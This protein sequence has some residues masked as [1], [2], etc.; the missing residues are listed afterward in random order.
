MAKKKELVAAGGGNIEGQLKQSIAAGGGN[1][2]KRKPR[3]ISEIIAAGGNSD[4]NAI[5]DEEHEIMKNA[6]SS[7]DRDV[8][9]NG[10][11]GAKKGRN[12]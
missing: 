7:K 2:R 3:S 8:V 6:L 4:S 10:G 9:S 11:S 12:R 5:T 1:D